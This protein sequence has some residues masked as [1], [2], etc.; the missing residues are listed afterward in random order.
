MSEYDQILDSVRAL[1]DGRQPA[2]DI[3]QLLYE[4]NCF[5]LLSA[6]SASNRYTEKL[7]TEAVLNQ[8]C[9]QERYRACRELFDTL[10]REKIPYAVIKGAV[11][12]AA[13][14]GNPY[15]RHSGDIDL[16]IRRND[17]D[18]VKQILLNQGFVQG[19]V[20]ASGIQPFSR[21]ELLFQTALSHQAAP[22][23]KDTGH[24]LCHYVNADVNMDILWGESGRQSDMDFVLSHTETTDICGVSVQKLSCEMEFIAL[25]LH[26]YKDMNSLYLLAQGSLKL[27]LFC[28][29]YFYIK[30][31]RP[32]ISRLKALCGQLDVLDYV[33]YCVYYTEQVFNDPALSSYQIALQTETSQSILPSFGLAED[34]RH[35]WDISF[36]HRIFDCDIS[37]YFQKKLSPKAWEKI[38]LN[39][40]YM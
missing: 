16:L 27:S 18:E 35:E 4:H 13:A 12:S 25:C 23:V 10:Q 2:M 36:S 40:E 37:D 32:D 17:I 11:L 30:R 21:R 5:Y 14:Y 26:H 38:H 9:I 8:I 6:V 19:R 34:E 31:C 7:K 22:F 3:S 20:T 1:A 39:V 29:I 33:Y 15:A 28:D 24:P